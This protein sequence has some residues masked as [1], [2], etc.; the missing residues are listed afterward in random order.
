[1]KQLLILFFLATVSVGS[2]AQDSFCDQIVVE[3]KSSVRLVP[4]Q[5]IFN[6]RISVQDSNYT[7]CA[8]L[9]LEKADKITHDF[10]KNGIDKDFIKTLTYSITEIRKHNY[11]TNTSVF[12][13]YKAEI[14]I[15]IK[16]RSDYAK[17]DKIFEIIK[18]NFEADFSLNFALTP[19]QTEEV[20]EKLIALA[21]DDAKQKAEIIAQSAHINLGKISKIQYG[22]PRII[23]SFANTNDLQKTSF[24]IRGT[25]SAGAS[26]LNP[27]DIEMRTEIIIA[28]QIKE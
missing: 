9:A 15:R 24:M 18:N 16:T 3:G 4:E 26:S 20:K 23:G 11:K 10:T 5:W 14:P 1:M 6:V 22:E 19:E 13:G 8:N 25:A 17:N 28:W 12:E 7:K 27:A 2:F 21:V